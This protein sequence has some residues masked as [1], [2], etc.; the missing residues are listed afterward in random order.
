MTLFHGRWSPSFLTLRAQFHI[1]VHFGCMTW[2]LAAQASFRTQDR[3]C[4]R[5]LGGSRKTATRRAVEG[6]VLDLRAP[7]L[8]NPERHLGKQREPARCLVRRVRRRR[9]SV[10]GDQR[11][12]GEADDHERHDP[13]SGV[14]WQDASSAEPGCHVETCKYAYGGK[15]SVHRGHS[16]RRRSGS[17]CWVIS[18][19]PRFQ[20]P[21][22]PD[23]S[24]HLLAAL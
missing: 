7:L 15:Q 6:G 20:W 21:G 23:S 11:D 9:A 4:P 19:A 3:I 17:T 13:G 12:Q 22:S 5:S 8:G 24:D 14:E 1:I 16:N 2:S 18:S 10:L